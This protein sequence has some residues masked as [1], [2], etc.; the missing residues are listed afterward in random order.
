[1]FLKR[2]VRREEINEQHIAM[3][4]A[5][6]LNIMGNVFWKTEHSWQKD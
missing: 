3:F 6:S 5:R 2:L 1:M 4:Q